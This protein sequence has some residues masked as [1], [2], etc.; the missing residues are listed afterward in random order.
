MLTVRT[1]HRMPRCVVSRRIFCFACSPSADKSS[2]ICLNKR[3]ASQA[4]RQHNITSTMP[5]KASSLVR[6]SRPKFISTRLISKNTTALSRHAKLMKY[7]CS[8]LLLL[9]PCDAV[10]RH[11]TPC[12]ACLH[13]LSEITATLTN[14]RTM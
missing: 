11:S 3:F 1:E 2:V 10:M 7:L 14:M 6:N 4:I 12:I 9:L 13:L 5:R 8:G